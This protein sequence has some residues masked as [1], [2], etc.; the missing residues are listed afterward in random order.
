M[1][2]L[3]FY[4]DKFSYTLDH[5]TLVAEKTGHEGESE[6]FENALVIFSSAEKGDTAEIATAGAK[7]IRKIARKNN[8]QKIVINPFAHLSG[9]LAGPEDAIRIIDD[10]AQKIQSQNEFEVSRLHFGWY[11]QFDINISGKENSQI[12]RSYE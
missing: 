11:K 3:I 2:N 6:I 1:K 4:C 10:M 12:F 7:D 9:N 5:A 8:T